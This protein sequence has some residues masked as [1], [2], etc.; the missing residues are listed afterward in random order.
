MPDLASPPPPDNPIIAA[1]KGLCESRAL[2]WRL[3]EWAW[4]GD[5]V[6]FLQAFGSRPQ[7]L[8]NKGSTDSV[9]C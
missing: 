4:I 2:R 9:S 1:F 5:A 8:V 3:G 7:S 6:D